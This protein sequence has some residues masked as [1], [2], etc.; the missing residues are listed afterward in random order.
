MSTTVNLLDGKG[1]LFPFSL[2]LAFFL[3]SSSICPFHH[4]SF[5]LPLWLSSPSAPCSCLETTSIKFTGDVTCS[6]VV[7]HLWFYIQITPFWSLAVKNPP[8]TF[9]KDL[10]T[11]FSVYG[12]FCLHV[13]LRSTVCSTQKRTNRVSGSLESELQVIVNPMWVLWIKFKS[14]GRAISAVKYW[15]VFPAPAWLVKMGFLSQKI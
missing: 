3:P 14:S 8:L 4:S 1:S 10:F 12:G 5:S 13:C 15:A 9:Q 11:L 7:L 6:P 2:S